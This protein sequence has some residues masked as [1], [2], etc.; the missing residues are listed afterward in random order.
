MKRFLVIST[1]LAALVSAA[2][3]AAQ[4]RTRLTLSGFAGDMSNTTITDYDQS[5]KEA[6]S[7]VTYTVRNT[8]GNA[9]R[10]TAILISANAATLGNGKPVSDCQWQVTGTTGWTSL[11]TSPV[12]MESRVIAGNGNQW[13]NSVLLRCSLDWATDTPAIYSVGLTFTLSV[14]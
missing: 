14:S 13:S 10:T 11:T 12:L 6:P 7:V 1:V 5:L 9:S 4:A 3:V 8:S 2:P